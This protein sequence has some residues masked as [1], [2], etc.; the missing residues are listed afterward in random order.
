MDPTGQV[1]ALSAAGPITF[2]F[3][4]LRVVPLRQRPSHRHGWTQSAPLHS[5]RVEQT[6]FD[7]IRVRLAADGLGQITR[8][9]K[10]RIRVRE[11][12]ARLSKQEV[13]LPGVNAISQRSL[14]LRAEHGRFVP[15]AAWYDSA[16][17]SR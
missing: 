13:C 14:I 10:P 17:V 12:T 3:S 6:L 5:K 11:D 1:A 4:I 8:E 16:I 15:E 7:N 2:W 9:P